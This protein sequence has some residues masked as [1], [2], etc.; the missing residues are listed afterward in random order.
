MSGIEG[1]S[2]S[3]ADGDRFGEQRR[4][5]KVGE[6]VGHSERT[7]EGLADQEEVGWC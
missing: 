3:A 5:D 4:K 1:G 7:R 6:A 2:I